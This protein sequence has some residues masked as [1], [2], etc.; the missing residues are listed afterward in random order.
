MNLSAWDLGFRLDFD[1]KTGF[2]KNAETTKRYL[3]Q[4][5]GM[6]SDPM[7][8]EQELARGDR[9]VYE[10]YELGCPE[11][12]G[13]LAFGTTILYP[14]TVGGEFYMTKGHFHTRLMTAEVYYC[15]SGQGYML[16]ENMDDDWRAFPLPRGKGVLSR[17]VMHIVR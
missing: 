13:D 2:S 5:R 3:S 6:F 14:G 11:R 1:T 7:A 10:F 4:M 8:Y 15:M 9:L 17:E 12:E 16:L